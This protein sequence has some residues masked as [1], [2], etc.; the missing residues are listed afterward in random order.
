MCLT[1]KQQRVLVLLAACFHQFTRA[2]LMSGSIAVFGIYYIDRFNERTVSLTIASI[3]AA[4][5]YT[6]S[7]YVYST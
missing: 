4:V 7:K 1:E 6:L 3:Q 5:T 2:A